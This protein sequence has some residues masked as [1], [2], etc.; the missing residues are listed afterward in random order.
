MR[1]AIIPFLA[2]LQNLEARQP[3][4]NRRNLIPTNFQQENMGNPAPARRSLG[5]PYQQG[6]WSPNFGRTTNALLGSVAVVSTARPGADV[7]TEKEIESR[8]TVSAVFR[9]QF[10][11]VINNRWSNVIKI[12]SAEF[13]RLPQKKI[14][15]H[16][17]IVWAIYIYIRIYTR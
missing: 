4:R 10:R 6:L 1:T 14:R 2:R 13:L 17:Y 9:N 11:K 5:F 8:K 3:G 12:M 7:E 15:Q 16:T